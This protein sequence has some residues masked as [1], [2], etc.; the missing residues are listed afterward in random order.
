M[1]KIIFVF[2]LSVWMFSS[3]NTEGGV[4]LTPDDRY[5]IDTLTSRQM[6]AL[7]T[8][9]DTWCKDSTPVF[10]QHFVDSLVIVR[11]QEILKQTSTMGQ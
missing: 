5:R 3:C 1:K 8:E 4:K 11:E 2:S 6:A 9:L 7:S 10:K